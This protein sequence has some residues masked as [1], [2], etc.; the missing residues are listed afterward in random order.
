MCVCVWVCVWGCNKVITIL[1][2]DPKQAYCL[3]EKYTYFRSISCVG[4]AMN[5]QQ[6]MKQ[7]TDDSMGP[8]F[9][10]GLN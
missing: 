9:W 4:S 3:P 1:V 5:K 8:F 7:T 6:A 10:H 2:L